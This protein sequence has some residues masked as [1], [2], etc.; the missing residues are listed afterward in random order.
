MHLKPLICNCCEIEACCQGGGQGETQDDLRKC[1]AR[2][3][4]ALQYYKLIYI[5]M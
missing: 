4:I 1:E 2:A 5:P 3:F